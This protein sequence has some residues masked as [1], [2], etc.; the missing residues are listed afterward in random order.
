VAIDEFCKQLA[1]ANPGALAQWLLDVFGVGE[2]AG[3]EFLGVGDGFGD[4]P[5]T[6]DIAV[7]DAADVV[8]GGDSSL[9]PAK[10]RWPQRF[11]G[12]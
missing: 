4:D 2:L 6:A 9:P 1:R 7:I 10:D 3:G 8:D 11:T 12:S 5:A